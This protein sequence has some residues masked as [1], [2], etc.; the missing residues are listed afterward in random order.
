[1]KIDEL[2]LLFINKKL[3]L[4]PAYQRNEVW[5]DKSKMLLIDSILRKL[6]VPEVMLH[7]R[8]DGIRDVVDGKQR[9]LSIIKF[10]DNKLSVKVDENLYELYGE[11]GNFSRGKSE[12]KLFNQLPKSIQDKFFGSELRVHELEQEEFELS[13]IYE[14]FKR[15]N[16][17]GKPLKPQEIKN[18]L[19]NNYFIIREAK[20]LAEENVGSYFKRNRIISD[21]QKSRMQDVEFILELLIFL[22][23]GIQDKKKTL[24]KMIVESAREE[25]LIKKAITELKKTV[26]TIKKLIPTLA[27]TRFKKLSDYYSLFVAVAHMNRD[28]YILSDKRRNEAAGSSL[29]LLSAVINEIRVMESGGLENHHKNNKNLMGYF[30]ATQHSTDTKLFREKR[31]DYLKQ[32]LGPILGKKD[33][34]RFFTEE[35]KQLLW[36]Q[37]RKDRAGNPMC[38]ASK[39]LE[40]SRSITSWDQVSFDHL[41]AHTKGGKSNLENGAV[42]HKRC[43]SAKGAR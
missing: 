40:R 35:E 28:Y 15:I 14:I 18:A 27:A 26:N 13:T 41:L 24:E 21:D 34:K 1:M 10:L 17:T 7:Y 22:A 3:N 23:F 5:K 25:T 43:N 38:T 36:H 31:A 8:S 42:V 16:S 12:K 29:L 9:I 33:E 32:I 39:C 2:Q 11:H 6:P 4:E 20:K 30:T 19:L 37:S